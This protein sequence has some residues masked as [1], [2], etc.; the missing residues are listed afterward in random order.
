MLETT[1]RLMDETVQH[2]HKESGN[3]LRS[4]RDGT[5]KVCLRIMQAIFDASGLVDL[6]RRNEEHLKSVIASVQSS[7]SS[8]AN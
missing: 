5:C 6:R 8:T 3:L 7:R 2:L 1:S 4:F